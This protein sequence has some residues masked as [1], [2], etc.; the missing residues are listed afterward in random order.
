MVIFQLFAGFILL[1]PIVVIYQGFFIGLLIA[2]ADRR[3]A[4]F[5]LFVLNL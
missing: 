5:S 3:T 2:Q 1:S 4:L